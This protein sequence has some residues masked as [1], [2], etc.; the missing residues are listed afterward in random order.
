M[1][2]EDRAEGRSFVLVALGG[3]RYALPAASVAELVAPGPLLTFPHTTPLVSG[4]LVR[5]GRIVPVYDIAQALIGPGGSP[6]KFY[7]I[8]AGA[9][10]SGDEWIAIPVSGECELTRGEPLAPSQDLPPYI[11]G[12]LP[13]GSENVQI[14]DLEALSEATAAGPTAASGGN[15]LEV[16]R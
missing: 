10:G 7:L 4:V 6:R 2:R 1:T 3:R 15:P 16:G 11:S 5:R 8:V 12:L 9:Y 13:V 14:L